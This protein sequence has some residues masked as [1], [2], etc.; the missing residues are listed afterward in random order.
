MASLP[1]GGDRTCSRFQKV[2]LSL[3][4]LACAQEEVKLR[5][6]LR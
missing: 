1:P 4:A 3:E 6:G 2:A 5:D